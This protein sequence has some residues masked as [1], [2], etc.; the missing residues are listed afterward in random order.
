MEPQ[1]DKYVVLLR[2]N[3]E[4]SVLFLHHLLNVC[5]FKTSI[6]F[7]SFYYIEKVAQSKL[8]KV[9]IK[10]ITGIKKVI[11]MRSTRII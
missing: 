4:L 7:L 3:S 11:I 6:L 8:A 1:G 9:G 10:C 2:Q 5:S